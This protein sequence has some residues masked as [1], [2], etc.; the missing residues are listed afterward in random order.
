MICLSTPCLLK[1]ADLLEF[2]VIDNKFKIL[3]GQ[4]IGV[5]NGNAFLLY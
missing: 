2:L 5:V 3:Y 1:P 4:V